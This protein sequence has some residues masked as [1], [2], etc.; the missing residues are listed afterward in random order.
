MSVAGEL[1]DSR[2]RETP[3]LSANVIAVP[4]P[5]D[6]SWTS[7]YSTAK[8][9]KSYP[10]N[11]SFGK[12]FQEALISHC[13]QISICLGAMSSYPHLMYTPFFLSISSKMCSEIS[14][15]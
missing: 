5:V 6:V 12:E 10:P 2:G 1:V 4:V 11:V 8:V 7:S 9:G 13:W 14:G 3:T 15:T